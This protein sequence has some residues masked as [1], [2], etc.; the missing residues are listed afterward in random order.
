MDIRPWKILFRCPDGKYSV[1]SLSYHYFQNT[2]Q[3]SA[4]APDFQPTYLI[5]IIIIINFFS[6][7]Q[8][9]GIVS[10]SEQKHLLDQARILHSQK[11]ARPMGYSQRCEMSLER[12]TII[13]V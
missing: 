2:F 7:L 10:A 8:D 3:P 4:H 12:G 13:G 1:K 11:S 6:D 9:L 5:R